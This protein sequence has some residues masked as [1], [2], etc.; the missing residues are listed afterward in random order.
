MQI[1]VLFLQL[2]LVHSAQSVLREFV[3]DVPTSQ[4]ASN[5]PAT[6]RGKH[7]KPPLNP[8]FYQCVIIVSILELYKID[9]LGCIPCTPFYVYY[10]RLK[11]SESRP[12]LDPPFVAPNGW[13]SQVI[14]RI[15][16]EIATFISGDSTQLEDS[17]PR[18]GPK[19]PKSRLS[20]L[21]VQEFLFIMSVVK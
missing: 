5:V 9:I 12:Y 16:L 10:I 3:G 8:L 13:K 19:G 17:G 20:W 1:I 4:N 2:H 6:C 7:G 15:L 18:A 14:M 11:Q 21:A